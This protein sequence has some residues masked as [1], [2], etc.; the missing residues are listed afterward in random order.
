SGAVVS[1][2]VTVKL[3]VPV[4]PCPSRAEQ[5]TVLVPSGNVPPDG[6]LQLTATAPSTR[7]VAVAVYVTDAPFGPVASATPSVS[8]SVGGV[9]SRTVTLKVPMAV[10][11]RVSEAEQCTV[12]T[13]SGNV[14]PEPGV[15]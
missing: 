14:P 12:L 6:V 10:L 5:V 2:T 3:P 13:P 15:Q 1:C 4:L 11:P 8:V 7:S 9:V